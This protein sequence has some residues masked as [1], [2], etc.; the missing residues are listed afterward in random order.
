[1]SA[2]NVQPQR[3]PEP[4]RTAIRHDGPCGE[5]RRCYRPECREAN[6]GYATVEI[7]PDIV[8]FRC[9]A[10]VVPVDGVALAMLASAA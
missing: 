1:M 10:A 5:R 6:R 8:I 4:R 2:S 3:N 7:L 9:H